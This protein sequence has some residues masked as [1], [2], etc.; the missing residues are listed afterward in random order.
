M[1]DRLFYKIIKCIFYIPMTKILYNIE[2]VGRENIPKEGR[3]ILAGNHTKWLDPIMIVLL[4][5]NHCC[6]FQLE[7]I[8]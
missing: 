5:Y 2:V 6:I 4:K 3:V 7:M 1:K 8:E